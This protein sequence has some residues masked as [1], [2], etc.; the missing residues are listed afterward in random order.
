MSKLLS[1][2]RMSREADFEGLVL[3]T[4]TPSQVISLH[5]QRIVNDVRKITDKIDFIFFRRFV[6]G[7]VRTSQPIAYVVDNSS[8]K[9]TENELADLHRTLWLNGT[10]PL[11]YIDNNTSVPSK[12]YID[13]KQGI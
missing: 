7:D 4:D 13:K 1:Q 6:K 10:I 2:L 9:L 8:S 5:E 12:T 3:V 11:L